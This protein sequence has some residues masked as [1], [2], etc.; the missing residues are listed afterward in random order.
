MSITCQLC[1]TTF[2]KIIPWQHLKTHGITTDQYKQQFGSLYSADTL[3]KFQQRVPHN[4]GQK[5]TD[6]DRLFKHRLAMLNQFFNSYFRLITC[7]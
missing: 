4:K 3:E 6:P 1:Q 2:A 7:G 5:V